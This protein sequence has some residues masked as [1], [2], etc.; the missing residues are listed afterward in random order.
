MTD[1]VRALAARLEAIEEHLDNVGYW[2]SRGFAVEARRYIETLLADPRYA[3]PRRLL[4]HGRKV[5]SQGDEDG[6]IA[7]IFR[8]IGE[9][10]RRFIEIGSGDGL[11]N[12]TTC[13]LLSGWSGVWVD[14][15][16]NHV[17]AAGK[18]F[19]DQIEARQLVLHQA[20]VNRETI[21]DL[22][23]QLW[24]GP[25]PD[26]LSLDIDGNDYHVLA[27]I[28]RFRPRV[29]VLE[30]NGKFPPPMSWVMKYNPAHGWDGSDYFGASLAALT[31]L[32]ETRGY[33]LVGCSIMGTNAFFVR[34][35]LVGDH[36]MPPFT[37]ENHYE[38]ERHF[39]LS[40]WGGLHPARIGP[41]TQ[42]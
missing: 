27:A 1:D 33:R 7:E 26:L 16:P 32:A 4:R 25:D 38:P 15:M 22:L 17:E 9:G 31:R 10:G 6:L 39:L 40:V 3:D 20:R 34:D 36:F 2:V 21:D 12:N 23:A 29:M 30:Y 19:A 42:G 41:F 35:D 37:A 13:L 28:T 5:Y 8:R 24:Q 11:E 14:A 18:S